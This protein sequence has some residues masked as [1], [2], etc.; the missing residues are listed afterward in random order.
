MFPSGASHHDSNT[1]PARS[2][3]VLLVEDSWHVAIAIKAVLT[4]MGLSI[5]GPAATLARAEALLSQ[6]LPDVAIVDLNIKGR[7]SYALVERLLDARVPVLIVSGYADLGPLTGRVSA[8]LGKPIDATGLRDTL[9]Q[10][11]AP[12]RSG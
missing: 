2:R 7:M 4:E 5:L 11:L 9:E 3:E 10:L 12:K 1:L 6:S 8:M